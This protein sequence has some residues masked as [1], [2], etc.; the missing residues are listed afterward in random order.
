MKKNNL[1]TVWDNGQTVINGWLHTPNTWTTEIMANQGWDSLTVDMQHGLMGIET[2]I[3]MMQVISNCGVVPLAR[4]TWN[5]TGLIGRLLDGGA[6]G[7]ICPMINTR[8]EAEAFVSACRYHPDGIRSAGP[9]R[10]ALF[11]GADYVKHANEEILTFA[12]IETTQALDNLEDIASVP[13]L[14]AF[15]V[16][17]GDLKLSLTGENAMDNT[18]PIFMEA[19]DRILAAG[20][21]HHIKVGIHTASTDYARLMIEKGC[22]FV[23]IKADSVFLREA[24]RQAV[25]TIRSIQ[26]E[27]TAATVY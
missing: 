1:K 23:T 16:G 18:D 15:Y 24:A 25:T 5:D 21:K 11:A 6:Y 26:Q 17:P 22:Q 2:A 4:A 10:A 7:I 20:Q 14:D 12:M 27:K 13:G 19:L 9:T 3:Q 8:A